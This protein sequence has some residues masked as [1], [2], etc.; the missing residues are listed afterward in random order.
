VAKGKLESLSLVT[1]GGRC[2]VLRLMTPEPSTKKKHAAWLLMC[3]TYASVSVASFL[4]LIKF[5]AFFFTDSVAMLSTFV[6]S[7]L[8]V[9]ASLVN[10]YAIEHALTPADREH[11]FG[12]GKAEALAGLAQ[13]AFISGSALFLLIEA[14]GRLFSPHP[15]TQANVG[16]GVMLVSLLLTA[17]LVGFQRYVVRHTGSMA[18]QADST[19]YVMDILTNLS[20][21]ASLAFSALFG[22]SATD[23]I[24]AIAITV[25]IL[26][27]IRDIASRSL[28]QLMDR[29]LPDTDRK[30][31][32]AIALAHPSV[33]N[34]HDLRTRTAGNTQFI[35][36]HLEMA[37]GI[38]LT[39]AHEI[40]D[41][42]ENSIRRAYPHAEVIIH[43]DP[44]E[45]RERRP[46]LGS[47]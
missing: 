9:L 23:P 42:V 21:V 35:Q 3:A 8:D 18:V 1:H 4:A 32:R 29:E 7:L 34:L 44:A 17:V 12:H 14:G 11:R 24:I 19:H 43:E 25:Y 30:N 31:I 45:I 47:L 33:R 26:S 46:P 22:W 10:L 39:H 41:E 40:S 5:A 36:L 27:S 38:T 2:K 37:G 20:V 13:S 6:D 28:D 15:I 16:I